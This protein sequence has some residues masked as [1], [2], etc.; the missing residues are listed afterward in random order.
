MEDDVA[1]DSGD[2]VLTDEE[3]EVF[4]KVADKVRSAM[5]ADG[6]AEDIPAPDM[7][8]DEEMDMDAEVEM[9]AELDMGDEGEDIDVEE[10]E[11]ELAEE[12]SDKWGHGKKQFKRRRDAEGREAKT[13]DV[14]GHYKDYEDDED[15]LHEDKPYT[16]KKEKTGA[17]KRIGA[18]KDGAEGT[19][20]KTSGKGRG[21][22]KG[23][24]PYVNE[25]L[26]NEIARRVA[27]KV[28]RAKK[29]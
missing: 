18:K 2:L 24:D 28:L 17:D 15:D 16:A 3:A 14:G 23:D 7:G 29:K 9:D 19:K 26:V 8:G 21:E 6:A 20:K 22:K 13:G 4:L 10:E 1:P 12:S 5:E 11:V 27:Q 25:E